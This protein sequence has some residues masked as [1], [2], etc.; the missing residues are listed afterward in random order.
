VFTLPV[1]AAF[2]VA[3]GYIGYT[4]GGWEGAVAR[5]AN[6]H[7]AAALLLYFPWALLQQFVFQFFLL[8]RL[9]H[10][11]RPSAAIVLTALA[12]SAVHFPRAPVM[13]GTLAAGIVWAVLYRRYRTL[14]PLAISH[15][16][17]GATLHYWVFGRDLLA[18]WLS[19]Q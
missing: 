14:L 3:G 15:A 4:A 16:T 8:G 18:R 5:V 17:L 7:L 11:L 6:W 10:L 12:F 19:A 9:L 13:A 2:M 1:A